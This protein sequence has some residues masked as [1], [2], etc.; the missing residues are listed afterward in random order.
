MAISA[1]TVRQHISYSNWATERLLTASKDLSEEERERDFGTADKSV[2][3]TL[4]HLFRSERSWF[5]RILYGTPRT[6]H[7]RPEDELFEEVLREWPGV[8]A[9]WTNWAENLTDRDADQ[10]LDYTDLKGNSWSNQLEHVVLHVVNHSTHH[11]GQIAG[12]LRALGKTPPP[13]DFIAYIRG[14]K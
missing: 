3:G 13:L 10:N 8:M 12:F 11:R 5:E 6:L 9:Q 2:R 4:T 1:A 14:L 7:R